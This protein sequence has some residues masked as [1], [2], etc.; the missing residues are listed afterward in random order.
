MQAQSKAPSTL[1]VVLAFATVYI[2]WGSTYFFI[3]RA[4]EGFP[5]FFLGAFRFIIAGLIM[6]AWSVAQGE[7]VFSLKAIEP[8]IITGLLL[9]FI[10]NGIV[11]WV[12]QFLPSAMVAIMISSSPLWF[13]VLDKPKWSE[14]LSNKS[15]IVGLLIGFAGV[16]LLFSE[17]IMISMSSM[18]S[19]RDLFAMALVVFGS[20]AWAG[21]SL[22]SKYKSGTDSA[23]VNSTWQMLAAGFA[24][25][26]GSIISGELATLNLAS[27]PM[28]AWLST[29]YLIVFGSIAGFGAY[30]WLLK[31]QP[32]TKVSTYAYV[33]PVV[34]VL[35]GIF[36][37][38]E[39]IS[40]LQI[41]GLVIILGSVLLINLHK[42]RK[43]KQVVSAY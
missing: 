19:S 34:A 21:G 37:A 16:V 18:N 15:T 31:V 13:I 2:V 8:A 12:E 42:Y 28:E 27:I 22:F 33:N 10:G 20:M 1:M 4:L 35:L 3:Q 5:P 17:K 43:P 9:L 7:N 14:N 29:L 6:L 38:N 23:S 11:I 25:L 24:F 26:P 40:V 39:S 30:V 41:V 32:A 36:F